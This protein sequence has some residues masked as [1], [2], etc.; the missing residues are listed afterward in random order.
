MWWVC[1][2]YFKLMNMCKIFKKPSFICKKRQNFQGKR[3]STCIRMTMNI[4]TLKFCLYK[5]SFHEPWVW[6]DVTNLWNFEDL[7]SYKCILLLFTE[8]TIT[9]IGNHFWLIGRAIQMLY[10]ST[11]SWSPCPYNYVFTCPY[12]FFAS[13]KENLSQL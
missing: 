11:V 7:L 4:F 3:R 2:A 10:W 6:W 1:E 5:S 8:I 13:Q 9:L 12:W